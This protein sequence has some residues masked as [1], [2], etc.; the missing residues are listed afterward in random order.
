MGFND[1]LYYRLLN[2]GMEAISGTSIIDNTGR[3][4]YMHNVIES[5]SQYLTILTFIDNYDKSNDLYF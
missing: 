3:F 2:A 4:K 5:A 1:T